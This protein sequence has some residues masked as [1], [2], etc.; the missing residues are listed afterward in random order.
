M[1]HP[2]ETL[3][4]G[5]HRLGLEQRHLPRLVDRPLVASNL[6]ALDYGD[7]RMC[8]HLEAAS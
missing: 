5:F 2:V 3:H 6:G 4:D 7:L 8:T 1:A